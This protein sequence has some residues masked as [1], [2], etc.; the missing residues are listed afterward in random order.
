MKIQTTSKMASK[1][2]KA[3][4]EDWATLPD[5]PASKRNPKRE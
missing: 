5:T 1:N 3:E 4:P 2:V